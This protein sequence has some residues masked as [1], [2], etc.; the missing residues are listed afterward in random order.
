MPAA[1]AMLV[2]TRTSSGMSDALPLQLG[3]AAHGLHA[4][5]I[6]LFPDHAGELFLAPCRGSEAAFPVPEAA[7]AIGHR[8]QADVRDVVEE[9]DRRFQQ[10]IAASHLEIGQREQLLAQLVAILKREAADTADLVDWIAA[11][12]EARGH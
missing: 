12:D 8:Q 7:I 11:L 5:D 6:N 10:A 9:G 1:S 4:G 3:E 2:A